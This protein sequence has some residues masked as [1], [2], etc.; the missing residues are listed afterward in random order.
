MFLEATRLKLRWNSTRGLVTIEDLWDLSLP[1]LNQIAKALNKE[2]KSQEEEDFL[3]EVSEEDAITK[4]K[5]DIVIKVL[6]IRKAEVKA[7]RD[8]GEAKA[9]NQKILGLIAEKQDQD[10]RGKTV[11]ELK[12]L[13]K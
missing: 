5:F 13:L 12:A 6:E 11:D 1:N 9:H 10:L 2:L 7:M 8:A 4:L 3:N